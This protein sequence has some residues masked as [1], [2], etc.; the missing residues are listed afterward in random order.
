MIILLMYILIHVKSGN[1][2]YNTQNSPGSPAV[3]QHRNIEILQCI[4]P[5]SLGLQ[6][7]FPN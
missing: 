6:H 2:V 3:I 1:E 7:Y 5:N 4:H